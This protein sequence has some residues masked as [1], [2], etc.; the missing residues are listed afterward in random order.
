[1]VEP[2]KFLAEAAPQMYIVTRTLVVDD[3]DNFAGRMVFRGEVFY[4]FTGNTYNS[5]PLP[6]RVNLSSAGPTTYPFFEFPLKALRT[7]LPSETE[8]TPTQ[9]FEYEDWIASDRG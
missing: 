4:K 3:P 2:P 9:A 7:Y 1:M 5:E 8:P 6:E